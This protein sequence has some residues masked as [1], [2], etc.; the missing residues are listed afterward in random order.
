M[1]LQKNWQQKVEPK[2]EPKAKKFERETGIKNTVSLCKSFGADLKK[3]IEKLVELY[4]LSEDEAA[5]KANQYWNP[6]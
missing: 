3:T 2:V 6:I 1:N 4:S 5:I